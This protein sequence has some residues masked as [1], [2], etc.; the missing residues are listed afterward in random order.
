MRYDSKE[1]RDGVLQSPMADGMAA[2]YNNL[3][4]VLAS[5]LNQKAK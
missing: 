4:E 1:V 3:D 2:G 5:T